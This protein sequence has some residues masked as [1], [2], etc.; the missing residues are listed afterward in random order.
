MGTLIS[1][2]NIAT[3]A[4]SAEQAAI[5][6]TSNNVANQNTIGYTRETPNFVTQDTYVLN[7]IRVPDGVTAGAPTSVRD[8]VLEQRVE[9]Q[10]QLSSQST[11]L[12]TALNEVQDV[13]GLSAT[14]SSS[15]L[16]ALGTAVNAFYSSLTALAS[17]PSDTATRQQVL[18]TAETL[19]TTFNSDASQLSQITSSLQTQAQTIV[20][21][22]NTLLG[23]IA[24]LNEKIATQDP[25]SD[26]GVLED[27]RQAAIA[28]LSQ[29]IGLDQITTSDN[30]IQL[31]T[32]S[33]G[34]LV[35]GDLSY[36]LT[37]SL[38][39]G[40]IEVT[41][42]PENT[43]VTAGLTGGSLGGTLSALSTSIPPISTALDTLAF[44]IASTVN[45]QNALGI[46]A[47]G[48]TGGAIFNK[49]SSSLGQAAAISVTTTNPNAIAAAGAGEGS[50]GNTNATLLAALGTTANV[51]GQT[52]SNFLASTL[53]QVG[54]DASAAN[55]DST[56]QQAT[57]TQLT[58][59][60]DALS[61]VSLDEEASNLTEFQ[62]SYQ[63]ASQ[64]FTI[65]D[66]LFVSAINLG[67]ETS[68]S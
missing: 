1:L 37:A 50:S 35:E 19:S 52:P 63:A 62:R 29:Y 67:V 14:S 20:G 49:L 22:A 36:P 41:A 11:T 5:N 43:D 65:I 57:L 17:N 38:V 23:T 58:T 4:L 10:T 45:A 8:R 68:V 48:N 66:S 53:A 18:S 21:Q 3:D 25:N 42:G 13:F 28:Q 31:T 33:G 55:N 61:G 40:S 59:Q 51:S 44:T 16:T 12:Q 7:G 9:Q 39:S 60:R 56:L 46:D 26:A 64:L 24:S 34:L 32:T 54:S 15:S 6:V 47:T 27:Q 2:L 30:G